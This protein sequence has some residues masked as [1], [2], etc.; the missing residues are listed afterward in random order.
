MKCVRCGCPIKD[1][2]AAF[3][4]ECGNRLADDQEEAK[5]IRNKKKDPV[6]WTV[7][8]W[9]G[10]GTSIMSL[11]FCWI[12]FSF[13]YMSPQSLIVSILGKKS[14]RAHK[15]ATAGLVMSII[16]IVLNILITI[17][18]MSEFMYY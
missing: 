13:L 4:P 16:A 6:V 9:I 17:G 8:A 7:F 10:M 15:A 3:C 18:I 1:E 14:I 11:L 5:V 2:D 12:P